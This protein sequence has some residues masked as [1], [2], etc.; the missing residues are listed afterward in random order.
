[1]SRFSTT[2]KSAMLPPGRWASTPCRW[3]GFRACSTPAAHRP[4]RF[5]SR[6]PPWP[7]AASRS[8]RP[9]T[10]SAPRSWIFPSCWSSPVGKGSP[11]CVPRWLLHRPSSPIRTRFMPMPWAYAPPSGPRNCACRVRRNKSRLPRPVSIPRLPCVGVWAPTTTPVL[12]R[13]TSGTSSIPTSANM[14]ACP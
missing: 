1:M 4:P 6:R 14:W 11:W 7:R 2:M 12:P 9:R 5:P 13:K 10:T 3:S 8:S